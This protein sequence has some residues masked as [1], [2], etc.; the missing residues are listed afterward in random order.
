MMRRAAWLLALLLLM[1]ACSGGDSDSG[2]T[3]TV[4]PT[5]PAKDAGTSYDQLM[6][7]FAATDGTVTPELALTAFALQFGDV[8]GSLNLA[9]DGSEPRSGTNAIRWVVSVWDD[10]S[11]AQQE[12]VEVRIARYLGS[13]AETTA[14][15]DASTGSRDLASVEPRFMHAA[16]PTPE[17]QEFWD[18]LAR[19]AAQKVR[20]RLGGVS[21]AY[22]IVLVDEVAGGDAETGPS[23]VILPFLPSLTNDSCRIAVGEARRFPD[24]AQKQSA[25]Y[26]E[27]F[28]CWSLI[29]SDSLFAWSDT[30]GWYQ[31]GVASWVGESLAGGSAYSASWWPR[32]LLPRQSDRIYPMF[33]EEY[34]A[35]GFWSSVDAALG[36]GLWGEILSLNRVAEGGD[37]AD[38]MNAVLARIGPNAL[39]GIPAE[40]AMRTDWGTNWIMSGPGLRGGGRI[41]NEIT[42]DEG[43]PDGISVAPGWQQLQSFSLN[44]PDPSTPTIVE[45][46]GRG[47]ISG[48]WNTGEEFIITAAET[49][50]FCAGECA[51]ADG[52]SIA[53]ARVLPPGTDTLAAAMIGGPATGSAIEVAMT[54]SDEECEEPTDSVGPGSPYDAQGF[55]GTWEATNE[56]IVTMF[57]NAFAHQLTEGPP[58]KVLGVSGDI[59]ITFEESGTAKVDYDDLTL[60]LDETSP[61]P[62]LTI[63]GGGVV[64]WHLEGFEVVF[65]GEPNFSLLATA[66]VL[67]VETQFP[68]DNTDL[69]S[70]GGESRFVFVR[71]SDTELILSFSEATNGRIFF[72]HK[73]TRRTE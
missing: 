61:I 43:V 73:W 68:I 1:A 47:W 16:D 57:N 14:A 42:I 49:L 41:S 71:D 36:G 37:N 34:S 30:P 33:I 54:S 28:H 23:T 48:R 6:E 62:S 67:G 60:V 15:S 32:Y 4:A 46:A 51:C 8:P 29:N 44:L 55:V 3:S 45:I 17:E 13:T 2:T 10:L 24:D 69:A 39:A 63:V 72:P 40:A 56:S 70:G 26:H 65:S 64:D 25:M 22:D 19:D 59:T 20:E 12:A 11:V 7:R 52:T 53:G 31:E 18:G 27:M 58:L 38:L 9:R 35:I 5:A 21:L 66:D 50:V